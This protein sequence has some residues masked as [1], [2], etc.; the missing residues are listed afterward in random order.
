MRLLPERDPHP[1]LH[2]RLIR[3][4][5]KAGDPREVAPAIVAFELALLA[6]LGFGLDLRRCGATGATDDLAYVSPRTGRA[7][8]RSAGH[9]YRDRILAL[10]DFLKRGLDT[11][12]TTDGDVRSGFRLTEHFLVRD[13]FAPRGLGLP[14]YRAAYLAAVLPE[15][16]PSEP[17]TGTSARRLTP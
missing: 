17:H 16:D 6:E 1:D 12:G 7:V 8:S 14:V 15:T 2:E 11:A 9:A 4:L 13:V 3:I 5:D 10:P